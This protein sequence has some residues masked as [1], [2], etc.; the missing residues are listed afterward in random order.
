MF[1]SITSL[2]RIALISNITKS[3]I[4]IFE[5]HNSIQY[6]KKQLFTL[7]YLGWT[8]DTSHHKSHRGK[9]PMTSKLELVLGPEEFKLLGHGG[10]F[11]PEFLLG[12]QD[13][14][15]QTPENEKSQAQVSAIPQ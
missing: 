2:K 15:T 10:S 13:L 7:K 3:L 8:Q 1:S 11:C 14:K 12:I 4:K 9:G 5:L 6:T